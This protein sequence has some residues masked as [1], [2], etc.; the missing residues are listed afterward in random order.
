MGRGRGL[1]IHEGLGSHTHTCSDTSVHAQKCL[2]HRQTQEHK[3]H[4]DE[5]QTDKAEVTLKLGYTTH[6]HTQTH[7]QIQILGMVHHLH[8]RTLRDFPAL[9]PLSPPP[10]HCSPHL[11]V[12][13]FVSSIL[14]VRFLLPSSAHTI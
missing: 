3:R 6:P 12:V 5:W 2:M 14:L 4:E 9:G 13:T 10:L 1:I 11:L 8:S 7:K